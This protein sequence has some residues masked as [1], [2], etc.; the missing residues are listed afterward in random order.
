MA[1]GGPEFMVIL[2]G[3]AAIGWSAVT[4][5]KSHSSSRSKATIAELPCCQSRDTIARLT[6]ENRQLSVAV[7]S[8]QDRIHV[9][10]TVVSDGGT[11]MAE[12]IDSFADNH[13][14]LNR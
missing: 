12:K 14:S 9:L 13:H 5:V 11:Q 8:L 1:L 6:E 4:I 3:I 2:A 7:A 10:E